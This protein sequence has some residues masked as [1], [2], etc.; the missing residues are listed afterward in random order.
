MCNPCPPG[1]DCTAG[2]D[3]LKAKAN[4]WGFSDSVKTVSFLQCPREYCC[5]NEMHASCDWRGPDACQGQR[6][7]NIPLCGACRLG[8]SQAIDSTMCIIDNK[9]GF[10]NSPRAV[11]LYFLLKLVYWL[12]FDLYFLYQAYFWPVRRLVERCRSICWSLFRGCRALLTPCYTPAQKRSGTAGSL[13]GMLHKNNGGCADQQLDTA[14]SKAPGKAAD[15]ANGIQSNSGAEAVVIYFFQLAMLIVP[16]GYSELTTKTD[17][18]LISVGRVA[19]LMQFP[20]QEGV[21]IHQGM[22]SLHKMLIELA[23]PFVMMALLLLMRFMLLLLKWPSA[24]TATTP[25][26][27]PDAPPVNVRRID[28]TR[29]RDFGSVQEPL[30]HTPSSLGEESIRNSETFDVNKANQGA[31]QVQEADP[32]EEGGPYE[33]RSGDSLEST[34]SSEARNRRWEACN[35]QHDRQPEQIHRKSDKDHSLLAAVSCLL[36][37]TY[38]SFA[39]QAIRLLNCVHV[40]D[41]HVLRYAGE[42]SCD[43]FGWQAPV[44]L[45]V[46]VLVLLPFIPVIRWLLNHRWARFQ[47]LH[48]LHSFMELFASRDKLSYVVVEYAAQPFVPAN[49]HW[50]SVLVLQR[51]LTAMCAALSTTGIES[52]VTVA[53]VSLLFL[54]L[55]LLAQPYRSKWVNILQGC[56]NV[57]LVVL[58]ILNSASGAFLSTGF[59]PHADGSPTLRHFQTALE[60]L[61]LLTLFPTPLVYIWHMSAF[62]TCRCCIPR[63][64]K[65]RERQQAGINA[66]HLA[67]AVEQAKH[68]ATREA[69]ES[70][71]EATREAYE[72]YEET[73]ASSVQL[74]GQRKEADRE[75][76]QLLIASNQRNDELQDE[77]RKLQQRVAALE[78][79]VAERGTAYHTTGGSSRNR[80]LDR[81][82]F[83]PDTAR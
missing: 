20:G 29:R 70:Y 4:F 76:Q 11:L 33:D 41:L 17:A 73:V 27:T 44:V 74:D 61:M 68:R 66:L 49:W 62:P 30:L 78:E 81:S 25:A 53:L 60:V 31:P 72:S 42:Q 16:Q 18:V 13:P 71:E 35:E 36:L 54:L 69:Y 82:T 65:R 14:A 50:A 22:S 40:G 39:S 48:P 9:C 21:C 26:T 59:N 3:K 6:D 51:L 38:I 19:A 5:H 47:W 56:A 37:F 8:F 67:L 7:P 79:E 75:Q 63:G 32:Q 57:C 77:R 1:A 80:P 64:G 10:H 43:F 46:A 34:T 83:D 24:N 23:S 52:S 45:L 2:G 12:C 28:A 55:H 15:K 58:A